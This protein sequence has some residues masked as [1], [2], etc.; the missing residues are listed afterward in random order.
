MTKITIPATPTTKAEAQARLQEL[1]QIE[2]ELRR[3]LTAERAA[4]PPTAADLAATIQEEQAAIDRCLAAL[5]TAKAQAKQHKRE[6]EAW[7]QAYLDPATPDQRVEETTLQR[8]VDR[9]LATIRELE[10]QVG[11]LM[12]EKL[13]ATGRRDMARQSLAALQAGAYAL[14]LEEDPRL[15]ALQRECAEIL[16]YTK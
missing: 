13:E 1:D 8:E 10:A 7:Q 9:R 16:S 12:I 15:V 6:I 4:G 11:A 2:V 3:R 5:D 14:P